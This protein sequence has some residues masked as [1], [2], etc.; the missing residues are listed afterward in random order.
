MTR[1]LVLLHGFTQAA[2]AM[3]DLAD[4]IRDLTTDIEPICVDLAGHGSRSEDALDLVAGAHALAETCGPAIWL[5]YSLGG[6]QALHLAVHRPEVVHGLV[7]IST[8]AGIEN[9]AD[10]V[11]RREDDERLAARI[12]SIGLEAF[13]DEWLAGP[14]FSNLADPPAVADARRSNTA[15]GLATSLRLAGTGAQRSLWASL[16]EMAKPTLVLTGERD[17]KFTEIGQRLVEGITG[18]AGARVE[19][20]GH[21]LHIERPDRTAHLIVDW[22]TSLS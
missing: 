12:E 1:R 18:A 21:S 14:L 13:L 20:A 17:E 8:T 4:R 6:R 11:R 10:R 3:S 5:G 16:S 7:L 2:G 9:D 19:D 15:A 22:L